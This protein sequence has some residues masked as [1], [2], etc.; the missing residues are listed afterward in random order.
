MKTL[1]QYIFSKILQFKDIFYK[2]I[3]SL[4]DEQA[5]FYVDVFTIMAKNNIE[6]I[7]NEKRIDLIQI[8][9]D[10]VKKCLE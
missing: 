5:S 3:N 6:E 10:L 9:V 2:S 4:D 1:A 8:I 7:L